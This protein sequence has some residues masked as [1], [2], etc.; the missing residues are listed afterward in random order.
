MARRR[1]RRPSPTLPNREWP[2]QQHHHPLA[3]RSRGNRLEI[4][5]I[6]LWPNRMIGDAALPPERRY[7]RTNLTVYRA[8][9]PLRPSGLLGPVRLLSSD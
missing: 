4:D 5:V 3:S 8:D 2:N 7:T 6:N 1:P 9:A